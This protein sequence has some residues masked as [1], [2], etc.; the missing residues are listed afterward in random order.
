MNI[1]FERLFHAL[2][3]PYMLL[4]R[5]LRFVDMNATYL[6]VTGRSREDLIGRHVFEAFPEEGEALALFRSAFERAAAGEANTVVRRLFRIPDG[7]G[8][9]RDVWWTCH[10]IP[11]FDGEGRPCGLLQKAE[12]V[13]GLVAAERLQ[14][15]VAREFDHRIKNMLATIMAIAR[16]TA[17]NAASLESFLD[18][19]DERLMALGRTHQL[20]VRNGWD[21]MN[22]GELLKGE[23]S[24]YD[25]RDHRV[26]LSG[27]E[28]RIH[29]TGAQALGLAIHELATNAAKY[30]A[31]AR[32]DTR[33]AVSWTLDAGAGDLEIVW[34]ET[35]LRDLAPPTA[36]GFG[37]TIIE[38]VMPL[39]LAARVERRFLPDGLDCVIRIPADRLAP[40]PLD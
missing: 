21:G 27:P 35:G 20:L 22:L 23:L 10:H 36:R 16:R 37:S 33:L 18:G 39:E 24:L 32:P 15:V 29:G 3:S 1:D 17:R 9:L 2:P 6:A 25:A 13:T 11:V 40:P 14:G 30:G 4:D 31:L 28:V 7:R 26:S 12:D 5:E 38:K 8:G 19:F 34:R